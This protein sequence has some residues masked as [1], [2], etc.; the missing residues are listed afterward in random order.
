M[1]YSSGKQFVPPSPGR[2]RRQFE[3]RRA[4]FCKAIAEA[5][6]VRQAANTILAELEPDDPD[7]EV[8]SAAAIAAVRGVVE[9][10]IESVRIVQPSA[11]A[12]DTRNMPFLLRLLRCLTDGGAAGVSKPALSAEA[13][14]AQ[15]ESCAD[16][17]GD[18]L[19]A[20][21]RAAAP[22]PTV[23]APAPAPPSAPARKSGL[24]DQDHEHLLYFLQELLTDALIEEADLRRNVRQLPRLLAAYDIH[25]KTYV[26]QGDAIPA[27]A[28]DLFDFETSRDTKR[29]AFCTL[30][31]A[32]A[33]KDGTLL[34][35]R[36]ILPGYLKGDD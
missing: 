27:D 20:I 13:R 10:T 19:S 22:P 21:D 1:V 24:N 36:V 16:L 18:A 33:G 23:A 17:L 12:P 30:V 9:A 32:L 8:R 25:V 34:R 3:P 35:G 7:A 6:N 2:L 29:E 11:L 15:A 4:A 14:S 26:P 28:H 31:P 5:T